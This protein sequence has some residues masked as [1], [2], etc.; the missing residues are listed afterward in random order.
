ME[1]FSFAPGQTTDLLH[2]ELRETML[3]AQRLAKELQDVAVAAKAYPADGKTHNTI[4]AELGLPDDKPTK[5]LFKF[6]E[7]ALKK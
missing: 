2:H 6:L 1:G 5:A 4:H 7:G 3:Q